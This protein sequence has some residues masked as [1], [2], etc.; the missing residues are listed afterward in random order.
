MI[1]IRSR[2]GFDETLAALTAALA[3][4][5][6][7]LFATIDHAEA[8]ASAGLELRPTTVLVFGAP[9]VGTRLMQACQSAGLDLPLRML[10]RQDDAGATFVDAVDPNDLALSHPALEDHAATL[11][12]MAARTSRLLDSMASG[13]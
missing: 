6:L 9:A 10:V 3:E 13:D 12:A 11:A 2:F 4:N 8:A 7:R 5:G 1:T